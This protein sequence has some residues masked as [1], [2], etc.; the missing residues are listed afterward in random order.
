MYNNAHKNSDEEKDVIRRRIK[1]CGDVELKV[2]PAKPKSDFFTDESAKRVAVYARVSTDDPK[3]TTS[4]EMQQKYY[5]D[6]VKK[7]PHWTLVGIYADE[8][9]SGTT[10]KKREAFMQMKKDC[11]NGKIDIIVTKSV[12]RFSRNIVDGIST[13]RE[14]AALKS[15]VGVFF[16]NEA[17]YSLNSENEMSISF[18]T[19]IA[20]GESR[21]KSNAMNSSLEMRFSNGLFLTPVLL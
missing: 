17:M 10:V 9:K 14:L 6:F 1:N 7:R 3:Q 12:S 11:I 18:L 8:G 20:E 4:Y 13:I 15:P 19:A 16:E 21:S 5:S 2:I